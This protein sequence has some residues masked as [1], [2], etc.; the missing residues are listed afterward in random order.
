MEAILGAVYLDSSKNI[1]QV[2]RVMS[3]LGLAAE[4]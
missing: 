2:K 4:T 1:G 3:V